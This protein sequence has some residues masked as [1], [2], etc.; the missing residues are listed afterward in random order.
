MKKTILAAI[1]IFLSFNFASATTVL[2]RISSGEVCDISVSDSQFLEFD[3]TYFGVL[4]DPPFPDGNEWRTPQGTRGLGYTKI[5]DNGTVRNATQQEIDGFD[6]YV[7]SDENARIAENAKSLM[8]NDPKY[9]R[10]FIALIK[11]L[12]DQLNVLRAQ[13]GLPQIDYSQAFNAIRNRISA[14][15]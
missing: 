5:N 8:Q 10:I 9:R 11:E 14:D 12:V 6:L 7:E 4:T 13:H 3:A 15:D 1:F 2:Y